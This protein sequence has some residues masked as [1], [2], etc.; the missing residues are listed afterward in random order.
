MFL[1]RS[2][3]YVNLNKSGKG[4]GVQRSSDV[5]TGFYCIGYFIKS[6]EHTIWVL[7]CTSIIFWFYYESKISFS[8]FISS[9]CSLLNMAH[10]NAVNVL[11][12]RILK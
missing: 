10:P 1:N 6:S 2:K 4:A 8:T 3:N 9:W 5:V 11:K 12:Y 7:E